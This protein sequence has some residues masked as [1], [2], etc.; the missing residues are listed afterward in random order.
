MRDFSL[1]TGAQ[2]VI[3]NMPYVGVSRNAVFIPYRGDI[4]HFRETML[5]LRLCRETNS[6]LKAWLLQYLTT[7]IDR[8]DALAA[9]EVNH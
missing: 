7:L 6:R 2:V 5:R 4:A 8:R 9:H 1:P 3:R